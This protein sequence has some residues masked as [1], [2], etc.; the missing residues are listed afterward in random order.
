VSLPRLRAPAE[1]CAI[2]AQPGL[3]SLPDVVD[4]N[5]SIFAGRGLRIGGTPLGELR[6]LAHHE[7][8]DQAHAYLRDSSEPVPDLTSHSSLF[9][10]GHQP[11][12]FHAGV[13]LK[14]FALNALARRHGAA[15][16]H[17][18]VDNDT[19]KTTAIRVPHLTV[20]GDPSSVRLALVPYDHF[21]GEVTFE[22]RAVHDEFEFAEFPRKVAEL[23][24]PWP[25]QPILPAFW[26]DVMHRRESTPLLGERFAGA[27]RAWERR[28]G[29]HNLEV[30][31]SRLCRTEAFGRFAVGLIDRLPDFHST[32]NACVGDY[33][34]RHGI[35]SLNHPVPDLQRDGD[36]WEAPFWAWRADGQRRSR[37]FVRNTSRGWRLRADQAIW[38]DLPHTRAVEHWGRL[39]SEGYTIRTRALTTTLF[40]RLLLADLFVHGIGGGKY[41][42]LTDQILARHFGV[43]PPTYLILTGTLHLP[44]PTFPLSTDDL[45]RDRRLLR[46]LYWNPQRHLSPGSESRTDVRATVAQRARLQAENPQTRPARFDRYRKLRAAADQ[47][48]PLVTG[49]LKAAR[50][51]AEKAAVEVA[52]NGV[53]QRRDYSFCLFPESELRA[54]CTQFAQL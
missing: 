45:R 6:R 23:T 49:S 2:L 15:P 53:L 50:R 52:A 41:D 35:R 10:A 39:H 43:E 30:P 38:P 51:D 22:E 46:D 14:N 13:W 29:C 9:L 19:A 33:R 25:F 40:A 16:L 32:Y 48:R 5:R 47:L 18:V 27:R 3:D 17:L 24:R 31:L 54:F 21:A 8:V 20:T 44:L 12:L 34:R 1:N 4:H 26:T 28:W 7:A 37:L 36:W 11:E 42:E